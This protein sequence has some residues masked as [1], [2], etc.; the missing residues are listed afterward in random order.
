MKKILGILMIIC[1]AITFLGIASAAEV[2]VS[3]VKFNVPDGYK[4]INSTKENLGHGLTSESKIYSNGN[5]TIAIGVM[6]LSGDTVDVSSQH[7]DS[8]SKTI[9]DKNGTYSAQD[10]IFEYKDG[11]KVIMLKDDSEKFEDIII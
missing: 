7:N 1:I 2:T 6:T 10:H 4:E 11:N 3:D 8:V 9:K 5:K